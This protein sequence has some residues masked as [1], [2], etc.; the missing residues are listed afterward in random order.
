VD[1]PEAREAEQCEI[2]ERERRRLERAVGPISQTQTAAS[3][4]KAMLAVT[5]KIGSAASRCA[6]ACAA[7]LNLVSVTACPLI[8]NPK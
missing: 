8:P 6:A 4:T 7:M 3:S 5:L 1:E 2:E